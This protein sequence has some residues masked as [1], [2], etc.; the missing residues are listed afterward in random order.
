MGATKKIEDYSGYGECNSIDKNIYVLHASQPSK[1]IN[2]Y[3]D[4]NIFRKK[5]KNYKL[6]FIITTRYYDISCLSM[7]KRFNW[8]KQN[9]TKTKNILEEILKSN[10]KTFIWNYETMLYFGNI[11]FDQLSNFVECKLDNKIYPEIIDGNF[12]YLK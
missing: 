8:N 11:Y 4:L 6:F 12:K 1:N 9:L 7:K 3:T 5:Y 2:N 10:E